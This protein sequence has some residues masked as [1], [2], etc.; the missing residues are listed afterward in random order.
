MSAKIIDTSQI[1]PA[2]LSLAER[3]YV[4]NGLDCCITSEVFSVLHP[5]LDNHTAAT[6]RFSKEL[7]GPVLEMRL[8]GVLVDKQR[9]LDVLERYHEQLDHLEANLERIVREGLG[10]VGFNYRSNDQLRELFYGRL[11]IP[12]IR[13]RGTVTVDRDALERMEEYLIARPILSHLKLMRDIGKKISVLGTEVD[14]DGRMRTSYNIGGTNTGRLSSSLSEFGTGGNLQNIEDLLRSVLIADPQMKMAYFDAEQGESRV[15]GGIEYTLFRDSKYLD[16]CETS[17][18]HTTV[19]KLVWPKLN[20]TGNPEA[21]K[22]LAEQP[23]YR[24]YSRRFMCKKIGHG[25]NY[26]GKPATLAQQARV[27][28]GLVQE[29]QP[30]YF[31]AFPA[32]LRWHAHVER[33][34]QETGTLVSLTGRKRQFWGRRNDPATLREAIAYDP[35]GSLADIVNTG[36]LA[37]WRRKLCQLLMQVHDAVV[38]QYLEEEEDEIIPKILAALRYPVRIGDR[39]LIIPYGVKVGWNFGEFNEQNNPSGLRS[40]KGSDKRKRPEAISVLDRPLR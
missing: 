20:W 28:I 14:P 38:V 27:D 17:D 37:L 1:N 4:Y 22:A 8:R 30:I 40:Y 35:Q 23:Y 11:R 10:M 9:R 19:A 26:D 25:T 13:K 16:A 29:F 7:Q 15:V 5:Q 33:E 12:A 3:E 31:R 24:H 39:D 36:M 2:S 32:H 6:Y 34:L 18:L 21:D